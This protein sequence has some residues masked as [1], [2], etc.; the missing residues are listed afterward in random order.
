MIPKPMNPGMRN[1]AYFCFL[2]LAASLSVFLLLDVIGPWLN[3]PLAA[4]VMVFLM[5]PLVPIGLS[6][7]CAGIVLAVLVRRDP[8]LYML[9][10]ATVTLIVFWARQSHLEVSIAWA[11]L[12][13]P[14]ALLFSLRWW[15]T[16]P[17][18][19]GAP[20]TPPPSSGPY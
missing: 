9:S 15:V 20:P 18:A 13:V 12:Y 14:G 6:A 3:R 8:R 10:L 2:G 16:R 7:G 11:W 1:A 19:A 4:A 5:T 17:S